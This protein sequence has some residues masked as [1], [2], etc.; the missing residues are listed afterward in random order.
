[1][2]LLDI[3]QSGVAFTYFLFLQITNILDKRGCYLNFNMFF[4]LLAYKLEMI[5]IP[6]DIPFRDWGKG[7]ICHH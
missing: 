6:A 5:I 2:T 7:Y 1:M 3:F 4:F